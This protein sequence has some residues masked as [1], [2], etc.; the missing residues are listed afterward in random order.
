MNSNKTYLR[1]GA[2]PT[3]TKD[4]VGIAFIS[5]PPMQPD[6]SVSLLDTYKFAKENVSGLR[7]YTLSNAFASDKIK[8]QVVYDGTTLLNSTSGLGSW[9]LSDALRQIKLKNTS[10]VLTAH[11][12]QI[13]LTGIKETESGSWGIGVTP[14]VVFRSYT[15]PEYEESDVWYRSIPELAG[16]AGIG[17][18]CLLIYSVPESTYF[19]RHTI[20][21]Q[22]FPGNTAAYNL[23]KEKA[24]A[25]GPNTITYNK[26]I[27]KLLSITI[28]GTVKYN[29][30]NLDYL[31]SLNQNLNTIEVKGS[32]DPDDDIVLE[33]YTFSE[34]Y[35]Y[36][37]YRNKNKNAFFSFDANPEYGHYTGDATYDTLRPTSDCL[38]E[39]IT[40]YAIPSA[41]ATFTVS[42]PTDDSG[43][44]LLTI[45]FYSAFS[46][47]ESHFIRHAVGVQ[48]EEI[49]PRLSDGPPNTY[50]FA[51]LGRNYY[52]ESSVPKRDIFSRSIPCMLPLGRAIL[53]APLNASIIKTADIRVRGGGIPED[54]DFTLLRSE[55]DAIETLKGYYDLGNWDGQAIQ[56]G[57]V[58]R[59]TVDPSNLVENGGNCTEQ[60]ISE[61]VRQRIPPGISWEL[62]F[63]EVL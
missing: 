36:L 53:K 32:V 63:E 21:N 30:D 59:I 54:F 60:E 40:I 19:P 25:T 14:G 10:F 34:E 28:N 52:D 37:G 15:L 38:I 12:T 62:V 24:T 46:Y 23:V 6:Y 27:A 58:V 39:Q 41:V 3:N 8:V 43:L 1:F 50:G 20:T 48:L 55:P 7:E 18:Q 42:A 47:G 57:G 31:K 11:N 49:I 56:E 16:E 35:V 44:P 4:A 9:T 29:S 26:A 2:A 13:K 33:Y 5:S 51:L 22:D 17:K 61:I 45:N